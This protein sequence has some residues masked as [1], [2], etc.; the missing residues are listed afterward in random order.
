MS[1]NL[2]K[3]RDRLNKIQRKD[4]GQKK[5]FGPSVWF[6]PED[7]SKIGGPNR[8]RL[9]PWAD[10]PDQPIKELAFYQNLRLMEKGY[11][12]K[13]EKG[14]AP[15]TLRQFGEQ[16]PVQEAIDALWKKDGKTEE[17]IKA[18]Q[19]LCKK[20]F[21]SN[22]YYCLV[23]V[24]GKEDEGPKIWQTQSKKLYEKLIKSLLNTSKWGDIM[25][26]ENGRDME[27]TFDAAKD[28][29]KTDID[30]SMEKS[31][32]LEDS[33]KLEKFLSLEMMP[34]P[35]KLLAKRKKSYADLKKHFDDWMTT[36]SGAPEVAVAV[37]EDDSEHHTESEDETKSEKTVAKKETSK[38][39][40]AKEA[41]ADLETDD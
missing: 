5:E 29:D 40:S 3:L 30:F 24:R 32:A 37:D 35:V 17:E 16:D 6:F 10:E 25:D 11:S 2:D 4:K 8:V 39:K 9:I 38:K 19:E 18:D 20:L 15:L 36:L 23:L 1:I 33:E 12:G 27:I 7:E 14:K 21:P 13:I 22:V 41:F 31:P 26:L 34:N 28:R